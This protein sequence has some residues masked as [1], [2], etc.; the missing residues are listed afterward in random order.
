MN[1][2]AFIQA[3]MSST[4][5]PGKVL[6]LPDRKTGLHEIKALTRTNEADA[7]SVRADVLLPPRY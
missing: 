7:N 5:L 3:R 2:L 6:Q 4:R 1:T